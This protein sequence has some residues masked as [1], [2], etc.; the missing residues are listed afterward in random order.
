VRNFPAL[1][2]AVQACVASRETELGLSP[3]SEPQSTISP[4]LRMNLSLMPFGT[5][6]RNAGAP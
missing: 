1:P 6:S 4:D 3:A 2:P 5:A